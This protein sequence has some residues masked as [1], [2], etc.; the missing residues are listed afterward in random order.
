MALLLYCVLAADAHPSLPKT[1]VAERAVQELERDALRYWY[2]EI[3]A[4]D[5]RGLDVRRE[6]VAF[7]KVIQA[8]F[9]QAAVIPFRFGETVES[10]AELADREPALHRELERLR[11]VVQMELRLSPAAGAAASMSGTE[12]LRARQAAIHAVSEAA[13]TAREATADLTREWRQRGTRTGIRCYA[14]VP[15]SAI[16]G[17][18][19]RIRDAAFEAD[20]QV[21]V[22]GPWPATEFLELPAAPEADIVGPANA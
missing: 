7:H 6:A 2:T 3:A 13:S 12:Y 14:L 21:R 22:S 10:L 11:D 9:E 5:L 16:D 18:R 15:R 19:A 8:A 17:F 4:A 20:V 1:G